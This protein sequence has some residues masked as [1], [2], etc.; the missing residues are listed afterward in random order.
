MSEALKFMNWMV[1]IQ[2]KH[3]ANDDRMHV[4]LEQIKK[5]ENANRTSDTSTK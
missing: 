2:N 5:Q 4:A 1:K 3:Y